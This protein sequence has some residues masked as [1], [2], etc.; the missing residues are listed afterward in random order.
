MFPA[1][2]HV[3]HIAASSEPSAIV[4]A[5]LAL[6][7]AIVGAAIGSVTQWLLDRQRRIRDGAAHRKQV[8]IAARM[9]VVDLSRAESNIQFC[10]DYK[11]WWREPGLRPRIND[12]DRRLV[13]GE[14]TD[15]GFYNVDLAE[16]AID[17]WFG[18][19]EYELAKNQGYGSVT[20]TSQ[21]AT[22]QEIIGWIEKARATLRELTGDPVSIE[23][24]ETDPAPGATGPPRP[25]SERDPP[26]SG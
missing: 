20:I 24:T 19:R 8:K 18:I 12:S 17:N 7:G 14:L 26:E 9:M 13:I 15:E 10:I 16:G 23:E 22:L 25:T 21:L 2:I 4:I 1:P 6:L 5:L 3:V 11:E